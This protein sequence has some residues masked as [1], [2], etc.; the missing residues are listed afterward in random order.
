MPV[1]F[2]RIALAKRSSPW[3]LSG[4]QSFGNS[5]PRTFYT[6][7]QPHPTPLAVPRHAPVSIRHHDS[8]NLP[9]SEAASRN[10]ISSLSSLSL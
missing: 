6:P 8:A 5:G 7:A 10:L 4:N 9:S 1:G 3:G 2:S